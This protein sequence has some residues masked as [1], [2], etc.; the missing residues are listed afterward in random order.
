M[1]QLYTVLKLIKKN[2]IILLNYL[3]LLFIKS[4]IIRLTSKSGWLTSW[5]FSF[6]W[7][8][9][10]QYSSSSLKF[11]DSWKCSFYLP[12]T[13]WSEKT[14]STLEHFI[15]G[16]LFIKPDFIL[17]TWLKNFLALSFLLH[18]LTLHKFAYNEYPFFCLR[19]FCIKSGIV[20]LLSVLPSIKKF[21][22]S[23]FINCFITL[24]AK[25]LIFEVTVSIPRTMLVSWIRYSFS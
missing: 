10:S 9:I 23:L 21:F 22:L 14:I 5:S 24:K 11:A 16:Y 4:F 1:I 8:S 18:S 19:I 3:F 12:C 25:P 17:L 20:V 7:N 6:T 2:Y 15:I 13:S